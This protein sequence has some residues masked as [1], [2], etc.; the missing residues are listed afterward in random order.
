[1]WT[2][3]SKLPVLW[4]EFMTAH[5]PVKP[6][7]NII[8]EPHSYGRLPSGS[9]L[10]DRASS[11]SLAVEGSIVKI[12]SFLHVI[13]AGFYEWPELKL[14]ASNQNRT[15][16]GRQSLTSGLSSCSSPQVGWSRAGSGAGTPTPRQRTP[17]NQRHTRSGYPPS[18][19]R[20]L[21]PD[22]ESWWEDWRKK[23]GGDLGWL[24]RNF[25]REL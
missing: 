2:P 20:F 17:K 3:T 16:R 5:I 4:R 6:V 10:Q 14:E 15:G 21:Q 11:R 24:S 1:M 8:N 22:P 7:L 12:Q 25:S 9:C 23:G 13:R 19:A 18:L